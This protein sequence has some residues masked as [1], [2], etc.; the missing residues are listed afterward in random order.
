MSQ[1]PK[2]CICDKL[3]SANWLSAC[4]DDNQKSGILNGDRLSCDK[5]II[6]QGFGYR[7]QY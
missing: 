4:H 2:A 1:K 7:P 5:Q 3:F 6:S